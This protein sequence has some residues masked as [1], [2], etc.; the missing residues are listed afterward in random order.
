MKLI[1]KLLIILVIGAVAAP[2][3]IKGPDGKPLMQVSDL[4]PTES[5]P[6]TVLNQLGITPSSP[7]VQTPPS[8]ATATQ[9][10][11]TI[12]R[13]Q[14]D[15]GQWHFSDKAP[16]HTQSESVTLKPVNTIPALKTQRQSEANSGNTVN[17]L[18]SDTQL[19]ASPADLIP[20]LPETLNQTDTAALL[21]QAKETQ[22]I[23]R[24]RQAQ[25]D[26]LLKNQ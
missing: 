1:I 19:A 11:S 5:L 22:R 13:W 24:E 15:N 9:S 25:I 26:A 21:E 2:L 20:K 14:D 7:R 12:Y 10:D 18:Q 6:E 16:A 17:T 8:S 23:I 4:I 3:F